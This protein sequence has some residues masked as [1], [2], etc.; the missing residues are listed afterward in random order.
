MSVERATALNQRL[1][2]D[3]GE[4]GLEWSLADAQPTNT[5][6]AHRV[7]AFAAMLGRQDEM[8]ERLFRAYFSE[9]RLVSDHD[10]LDELA[11]EV[12]V[13]GADE[14]LSGPKFADEVRRDEEV[15]AGLGLTSVPTLSFNGRVHVSGTRGRDAMLQ[16]LKGSWSEGSRELV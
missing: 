16:E 10:T 12:G 4:I 6:D 2:Q 13:A 1:E 3:A 8:L 15:A 14:V 11:L 5:F 9:G 7:I